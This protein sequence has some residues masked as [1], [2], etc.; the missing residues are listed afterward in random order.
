MGL[1]IVGII[2]LVYGI[3]A[4]HPFDAP[5]HHVAGEAAHGAGGSEGT[6]FWAVLLQNCTF[7]LLLVNASMFFLCVTTMAHGGWQVAFRR[8]PE[9]ISSAVPVLGVIA[10]VVFIALVGLHRTD[11]YHWLDKDAVAADKILKNKSGFLNPYFYLIGSGLSIFLW[12]FL[13]KKMRT[14]SL[15][16]D[17]APMDY[18]TSKSWIWKNTVWASLFTVVFGL[19]VAS[20]TP[21]LWLMSIDAHWYST[22]FS[23]YTFASTFVSGMALVALYVMW[24]KGKGALEYV[25]D[26]HLHDIG[27][28]MFAFSVFWT[29]LWFSQ[30]MLIWYSN[31]PEETRYFVDRI[32][33]AREPGP[34][35]AIFF[36]NLILN[37]IA[38]L[39]ILMKKSTKR[40]YTV[41]TFMAIV[42][43]FGHW[44][45]FFQMIM[46]GTVRKGA[47]LSFFE[48]GIAAMFVGI[49]MW[50]VGRYLTSHPTTAK[51]HPYLK[52]SII[53]HT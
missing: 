30:Y 27:K 22:M 53:H 14:L 1:L 24:L 26:E 19:T 34:Y 48:F 6:R 46:P 31:Q 17:E 16:T 42:I 9:A 8:V 28:F 37:F 51:N 52:E 5:V 45:D 47:G 36:L 35:K 43:I 18:E 12:W 7:W 15:Q 3:F 49:I 39:L 33:T 40:S 44:I 21:W 23:W 32:G 50:C 41:V 4:Y 2:A 38:P 13:G 20:T 11:I 25:T 10:F 29:Y